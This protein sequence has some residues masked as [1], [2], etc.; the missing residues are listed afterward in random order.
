MEPYSYLQ[1]GPCRTTASGWPAWPR[2][3]H[4]HLW[5]RNSFWTKMATYN[6]V[7]VAGRVS[8]GSNLTPGAIVSS[9]HDLLVSE[10][11]W[12]TEDAW[13]GRGR[14]TYIHDDDATRSYF[15]GLTR[16]LRSA[17]WE[18]DRNNI[19]SLRHRITNEI[20]E[21]EPGG[22]GTTGH[23]LHH[24]K[25]LNAGRVTKIRMKW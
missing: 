8:W 6:C 11:Y 12:M 3:Q 17:G 14:R 13:R 4:G 2:L 23:F 15:V 25:S 1:A 24:M 20:I 9:T 16:R 10:G 22:A 7:T 5:D 18:V 19:R 21:L